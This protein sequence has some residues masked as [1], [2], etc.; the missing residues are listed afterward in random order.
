M[1]PKM[2]SAES[3]STLD[4]L[5]KSV[6]FMLCGNSELIYNVHICIFTIHLEL[7]ASLLDSQHIKN[8]AP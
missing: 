5:V 4:V 2:S 8:I 1:V 3:S 7:L 6:M